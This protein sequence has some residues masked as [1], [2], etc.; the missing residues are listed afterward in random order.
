MPDNEALKDIFS[1][2]GQKKSPLVLYSRHP[3]LVKCWYVPMSGVNRG[4]RRVFVA[5]PSSP[6]GTQ[7]W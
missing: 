4:S 2:A 7:K 5:L 6:T 1:T 3:Y